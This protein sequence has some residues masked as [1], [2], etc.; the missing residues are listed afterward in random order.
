[1]TQS[2]GAPSRSRYLLAGLAAVSLVAAIGTTLVSA[3]L[4]V[5]LGVPGTAIALALMWVIAIL[6]VG[7]W[8]RLAP[9]RTLG[10]KRL[11]RRDAM[12]ALAVGLGLAIAVPLLSVGAATLT[13]YE[14]GTIE[15]AE[16]FGVGITVVGVLTAAVTEEVIYRAAAMGALIALRAPTVLV[17][18][19]PA[20]LFTLTH[21]SWGLPHAIFVVFPLSI[22]LGALFL[23]RRS[24]PVNIVAHL[25]TDLPVVVLAA[26][27]N[28]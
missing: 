10:L 20:L 8:L 24:L 17:L 7:G 4:A 9:A 11:H 18:V 2:S 25:I 19:V 16:Q 28:T 21:W 23:W 27:A 12:V 15:T 13:G 6:V 1:M 5:S 14:T 26:F 22:G 3:P